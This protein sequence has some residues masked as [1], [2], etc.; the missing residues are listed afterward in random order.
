MKKLFKIFLAII[1]VILIGAPYFAGRILEKDFN[2]FIAHINEIGK[3]QVTVVGK[4]YRGFFSSTATT[5][6]TI[7]NS[8]TSVQL[9]HFIKHGPVILNFNGWFSPTSY[10]PRGF[11]MGVI[12]TTFTGNIQ[13][14]V[15]MVYGKEPG[16]EITTAISLHGNINTQF[17]TNPFNK[18]LGQGQMNWQGSKTFFDTDRELSKIDGSTSIPIIEYSETLAP[19]LKQAVKINNVKIDFASKG[20]LQDSLNVNLDDIKLLNNDTTELDLQTY[21]LVIKRQVTNDILDLEIKKSFKK[22]VVGN[23]AYGP[24]D[25]TL[26]FKNVSTKAINLLR[27]NQEQTVADNA[28]SDDIMLQFLINKITLAA[29]LKFTTPDG[30]ISGKLDAALGDPKITAVTPEQILPTIVVKQNIQLNKKILYKL[31]TQF[32]QN[33]IKN[34]E[35]QFYLKNRTSTITNPY[36]MSPE[37]RLSVVNAWVTKVVAALTVQKY[38]VANGDDYVVDIDFS[39]Q[40]LTVNG[41]AKAEADVGQLQGLL[42]VVPPP[43]VPAPA[44]APAPANTTQPTPALGAPGTP[45]TTAP[46]PTTQTTTPKGNDATSNKK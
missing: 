4:Y 43:A 12:N 35:V 37:Q 3:D 39:N 46:A 42:E 6:I 24:L 21:A 7:K 34:R 41:L 29:T 40:K 18:Q 27:Q 14:F 19:N 33:Q 22:L 16:Y 45:S 15:E 2:G 26:D 23:D 5:E 25:F 31:L 17:N 36:T 44:P 8:Y 11:N 30:N 38:I 32:A 10:I 28:V 1:V 9:A 13:K 20:Y